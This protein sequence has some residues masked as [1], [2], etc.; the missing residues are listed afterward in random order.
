MSLLFKIT[1]ALL[2]PFGEDGYVT[3]LSDFSSVILML[4]A[5]VAAAGLLFFFLIFCIVGVSTM[6]MLFR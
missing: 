3:A 6:T 5:L 2:Q 1:A 4:F